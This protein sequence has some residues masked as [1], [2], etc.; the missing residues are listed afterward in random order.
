M[1][2]AEWIIAQGNPPPPTGDCRKLVWLVD[3]DG[4]GWIG[5]RAW[6]GDKGYWT[7]NGEREESATV[8][9]WMDLPEAP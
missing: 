3:G 4:M 1:S 8:T 6:R 7:V 2:K 5:I 9:R